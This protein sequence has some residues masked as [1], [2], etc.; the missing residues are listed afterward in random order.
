M[1]AMI[2]KQKEREDDQGKDTAFMLRGRLVDQAK[3]DRYKRDHRKDVDILMGEDE[4]PP[5]IEALGGLPLS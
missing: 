3:I 5:G 2:R 1:E 4:I